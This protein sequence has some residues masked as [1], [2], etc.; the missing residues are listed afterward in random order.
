MTKTESLPTPPAGHVPVRSCLATPAMLRSWGFAVAGHVTTHDEWVKGDRLEVARGKALAAGFTFESHFEEH[1]RT[2]VGSCKVT[3][4]QR[5]AGLE[6]LAWFK[7][8]G[9]HVTE[10]SAA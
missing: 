10:R 2:W 9:R 7:A 3:E 1:E 4:E 6:L 5:A 8:E